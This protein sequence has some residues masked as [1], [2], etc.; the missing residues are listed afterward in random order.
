[1]G[2]KYFLKHKYTDVG[3]ALS[4]IRKELKGLWNTVDG[5][6]SEDVTPSNIQ[7]YVPELSTPHNDYQGY[8]GYFK[9]K[10]IRDDS[11]YSVHIYDGAWEGDPDYVRYADSLCRVNGVSFDVSPFISKAYHIDEIP[12]LDSW[13]PIIFALNF[14]ADISLPYR[15]TV[16]IVDIYDEGYNKLPRN[17]SKTAWIQLGRLYKDASGRVHITQDH[18]SGVAEMLWFDYCEANEV[19]DV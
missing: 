17:T 18:L 16:R 10:L 14:T 12:E 5:V 8:M 9:L 2:L 7:N 3:E 1:M 4:D 15:G 19:H 13:K 11:V 6:K